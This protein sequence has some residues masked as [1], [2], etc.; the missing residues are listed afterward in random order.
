[1]SWWR[2]VDFIAWLLEQRDKF[3]RGDGVSA[4][5]WATTM[6]VENICWHAR[7]QVGLQ[8]CWW[9]LGVFTL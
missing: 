6:S 4:G 8:E 5:N 9:Q 1:M 7:H 2:P 3:R